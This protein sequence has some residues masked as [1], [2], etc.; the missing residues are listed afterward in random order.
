MLNFE[1]LPE[2]D[3]GG[4]ILTSFKGKIVCNNTLRARLDYAIQQSLPE[5]RS[6][7]FPTPAV[8]QPPN[9]QGHAPQQQEGLI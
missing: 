3:L 5:V 1:R 6:N 7:L 4:V 9:P 8:Q 2:S